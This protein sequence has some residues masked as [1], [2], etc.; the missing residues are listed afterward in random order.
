MHTLIGKY[1]KVFK[2]Y[3]NIS[4]FQN[5]FKEKLNNAIW[6]D[7]MS[8]YVE[9]KGKI[10]GD[11]ELYSYVRS[12]EIVFSLELSSPLPDLNLKEGDTVI[13]HYSSNY[14]TYIR[15]GDQVEFLGK[16]REKHLKHKDKTVVWIEAHQL[17]NESLQFSFDY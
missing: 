12:C 15:E 2:Q 6:V 17:Y 4:H 10:N 8:N 3:N 9:I 7:L 16:V 11:P 5:L 14:I 1:K 13:V